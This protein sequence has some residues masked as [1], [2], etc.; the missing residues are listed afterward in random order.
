MSNE[1]PE[2]KDIREIMKDINKKAG[3]TVVNFGNAIEVRE[4]LPFKQEYLN[5][6]TGGGIP[7]GL[8]TT[9]WGGESGGKSS[10]VLDLISQAQANNKTCVYI[11]LEH[12]FD[13]DWA[14][15]HGVDLEKLIYAGGFTYAEQSMDALIEFCKSEAADLIIVDSVHGM[16]P[17]GEQEEKS[18]KEKSM[19]DDSMA[20]L[21]RK[22]SQFFRTV[23]GH[24]SKA[25]TA[26]VLIGQ[27]RTDLGAFVK[28]EKLSGGH[29]LL[30]WSSL[31]MQIRR[32][33]KAD[34]PTKKI[35][36]E[37][38]KKEDVIIGFS[39]VIKITKSKVGGGCEGNDIALPFYFGH[40]L[41]NG[42]APVVTLSEQED[43]KMMEEKKKV[44]KVKKVE[45]VSG[46]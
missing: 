5:T 43:T 38:G 33:Q 41:T 42:E 14:I 13:P 28:L 26:V 31:I 15:K 35:V 36:N 32:G 27:T 44:K 12:S 9:L 6:L 11:D 39:S 1:A 29:A 4:R 24:V 17:K 45:V 10:I 21:A 19:E 34:A 46:N 22:L 37:E 16:S 2:K 8:F 30:H 7:Y 25:K 20:L 23:A 3:G 40:G 18:G